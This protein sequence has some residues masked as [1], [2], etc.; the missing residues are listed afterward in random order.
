MVRVGPPSLSRIVMAPCSRLIA[1]TEVVSSFSRSDCYRLER[2]LPG[3]ARTR[4]VR[5]LCTA[6]CLNVVDRFRAITSTQRQT[7]AWSGA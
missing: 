2:Q 5:G 4:K 7:L 1:S 3:R 6:L